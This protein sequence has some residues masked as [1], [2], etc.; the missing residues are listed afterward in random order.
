[1]SKP[2]RNLVYYDENEFVIASFDTIAQAS[3]FTGKAV[4]SIDNALWRKGK[5]KDG[6]KIMWVNCEEN[7]CNLEE[8]RI[9]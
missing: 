3:K 8:N 6:T 9:E 2:K 5:F 7:S 1:M 4:S